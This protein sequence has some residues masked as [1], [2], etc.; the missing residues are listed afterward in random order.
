MDI[1]EIKTKIDAEVSKRNSNEFGI[2]VGGELYK[3]LA[4]SD[5]IKWVPFSLWG[6]GAFTEHLPAYEGKHFIF[7]DWRL[8]DYAFEVGTPASSSQNNCS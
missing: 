6:T 3:E 8:A 4:K 5:L 2:R 7:H 1:A